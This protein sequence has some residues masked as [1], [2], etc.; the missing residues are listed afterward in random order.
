MK[1]LLA[2]AY[3]V[4]VYAFFFVTFLYAIGFIGN[5]LVSK[6]ID[7]GPLTS[8]TTALI[9]DLVL[10]GLFA[11]QHSGMAR[12]GFKRALTKVIGWPI[13]R[14]TYVLV[15]TIVLAVLMWQWRPIP[16]VI[17][18]VQNP[19]TIA[20]LRIIY[21]LSWGVL[22]IS[23]FLI[24]HFDLFGLHQVYSYLRGAPLKPLPF[25]TPSLYRVVRHPIYLCFLVAFWATPTMTAGHLL[26]SVMTT[27]YI[28]VGI[29]FEERDLIHHFGESYRA[30][31]R[32]VP[33]LFP[34]LGRKSPAAGDQSKKAR[35]A[36]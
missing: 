7:N 9:I 19:T 29:Q 8:T 11:V 35:G 28:F 20:A 22:L 17:W 6:N 33:M 26:F 23:T 30:Y 32:S 16:G 4:A 3:G 12:W 15:A 36:A 31:R 27:G 10:L 21:L 25:K 2:F 24:N 18:Q 13:E 14:S 5:L 34:F 1:K